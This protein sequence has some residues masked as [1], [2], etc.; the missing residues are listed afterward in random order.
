MLTLK[1]IRGDRART[2]E[3]LAVKGFAAA[4]ETIDRIEALDDRRKAA[5]SELDG[6]LAR[7]N[8]AAKEIG[9][10][11]GQGKR[12][13]AEA[14]KAAVADLKTASR[15][16]E[17]ELRNAAAELE[18]AIVTLPNLPAEIVPEGR[19][20]EDNVVVKLCDDHTPLAE[21]ALPHW[22]LAAKYGIIDFEL[23]VK[24][25]GAGFPVYKGRGAAL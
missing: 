3:R 25:T 23:G 13:E 8:A 12:D 16:L 20:A 17:E 15:G 19:T 21:G 6:L 5:Q 22:E 11:M 10:L 18:A 4:T 14:A 1:Q 9:T 7:Q 24:L 2:I